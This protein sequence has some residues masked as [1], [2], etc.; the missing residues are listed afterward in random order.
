[1]EYKIAEII[2]IP[3]Y[4]YKVFGSLPAKHQLILS[5]SH[6]GFANWKILVLDYANK[7]SDLEL[8]MYGINRAQLIDD[9][10]LK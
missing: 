5:R 6:H 4:A 2:E 3:S 10:K 7:L 8:V 1:M 9:G